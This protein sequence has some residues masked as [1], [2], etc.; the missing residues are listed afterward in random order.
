[1]RGLPSTRFGTERY[2]EKVARRLR[3][4]NI[5]A[6]LSA[7]VTAFFAVVRLLDPVPGRWKIAAVNAIAALVFALIP[8]LHRFGPL[9]APL[10]FVV[11]AYLFIL[12]VISVFGTDGGAYLYYLM[13]TALG[14]LFLGTEQ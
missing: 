6:W 5:A 14:I 9:C 3:A 1:M 11:V 8:L 10:A 12:W 2:P 13:A 4:V 7:A